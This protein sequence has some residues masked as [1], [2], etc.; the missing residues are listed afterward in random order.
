MNLL[1][2]TFII[3]ENEIDYPDD[4]NFAVIIGEKPS[5]GARSPKLWNAA[6]SS[7]SI[8]SKMI[9]MD[10]ANTNFSQLLSL[11]STNPYFLGG[12]IA[13]PYKVNAASWFQDDLSPE[14]FVIG[15]VNS[16]FRSKAGKLIGTNTDGEAAVDSLVHYVGDIEGKSILVL[17]GGGTGKAVIAYLKNKIGNTGRILLACRK[18][19]PNIQM[20]NRLKID[21]LIEWVDIDKVLK[22]VDVVIN[23]TSIGTNETSDISPLSSDQLS[24]LPTKAIVFDINYN[25]NPTKLLK[26]SKDRG[27]ITIDGLLMNKQQAVLSFAYANNIASNSEKFEIINKSMTLM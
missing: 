15:S 23:C 26:L 19:F 13:V 21:E 2:E 16:M 1:S 10:V 7:L 17:G 8:K 3:L 27:L 11:L 12:S 20:I 22:N 14:A 25:P 6:F 4:Q 9:A 18:N 24:I 5:K